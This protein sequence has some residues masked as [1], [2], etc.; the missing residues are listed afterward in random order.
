MCINI[1]CIVFKFVECFV[2]FTGDVL[3]FYHWTRSGQGKL[4]IL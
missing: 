2:V 3:P 4:T 1:V